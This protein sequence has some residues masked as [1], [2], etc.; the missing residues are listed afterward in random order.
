[1][2]APHPR[3]E[4]ILELMT[5][6]FA[7]PFE[8][9]EEAKGLHEVETGR[10]R[11]L[12]PQLTGSDLCGVDHSRIRIRLEAR[13]ETLEQAEQTFRASKVRSLGRAVRMPLDKCRLDQGEPEYKLGHMHKGHDEMKRGL[14]G[15]FLMRPED[16]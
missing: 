5:R 7:L 8:S 2:V 12:Q 6:Q 9:W 10:Q 16:E 15:V 3:R 4:K 1:M 13:G 14:A 11:V